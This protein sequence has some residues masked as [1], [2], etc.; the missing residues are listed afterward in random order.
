[1]EQDLSHL[2]GD[3]EPTEPERILERPAEA[4]PLQ[5]PAVSPMVPSVLKSPLPAA[6]HHLSG[7]AA[8]LA[9]LPTAAALYSHQ[10]PLLAP[11]VPAGALLL[12][13]S[14]AGLGTYLIDGKLAAAA[15]LPGFAPAAAALGPSLPV[16]DAASVQRGFDFGREAALRELVAQDATALGLGG[17]G[18]S[19][20]AASRPKSSR[21]RFG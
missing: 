12:N 4:P 3:K 21:N 18:N 15:A 14:Y 6:A 1:M 17:A 19:L 20:R 10:L 16:L 13:P 8:A 7:G 2:I 11:V 5:I 9:A